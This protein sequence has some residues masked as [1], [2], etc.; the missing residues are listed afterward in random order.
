MRFQKSKPVPRI[1][2]FSLGSARLAVRTIYEC[3]ISLFNTERLNYFNWT[4]KIVD[5]A[6]ENI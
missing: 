3:F 6:S 4:G 2:F 5:I 1:L